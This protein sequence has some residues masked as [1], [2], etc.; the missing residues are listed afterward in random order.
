MLNTTLAFTWEVFKAALD[1]TD[2]QFYKKTAQTDNIRKLAKPND[3]QRMLYD[4]NNKST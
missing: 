2:I 3:N 1:Y 4:H